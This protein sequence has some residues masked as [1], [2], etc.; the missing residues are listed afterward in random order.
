VGKNIM[1]V[2]LITSS[3][4]LLG[5]AA[6]TNFKPKT[7]AGAQCKVQCSQSMSN[8]IGSSYTCDRAAST[9][10]QSCAELDSVSK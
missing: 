6:G 7:Q 3:L 9:C 1:A 8:C 5:C 4:G 2:L 10:M